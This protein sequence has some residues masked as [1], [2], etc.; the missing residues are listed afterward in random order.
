M[1]EVCRAPET[2]L[3]A[4]WMTIEIGILPFKDSCGMLPFLLLIATTNLIF[5]MLPQYI[6]LWKFLQN[7]IFAYWGSSDVR[8]SHEA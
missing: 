1:E 4:M 6:S 5:E 3:A 2:L 8:G 7:V